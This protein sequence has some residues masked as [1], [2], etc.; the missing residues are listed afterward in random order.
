MSRF[1]KEV[2]NG[3]NWHTGMTKIKNDGKFEIYIENPSE[4][5]SIRILDNLGKIIDTRTV[6]KKENQYNI[7][8]LN[9]GLYFIEVVNED[10]IIQKKIVVN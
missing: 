3:E 8:T 5:S 10:K 7:N 1:E 4:V 6:V 2:L 9:S